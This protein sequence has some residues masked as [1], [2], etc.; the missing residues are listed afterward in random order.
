MKKILTI[1]AIFLLILSTQC[2]KKQPAT[3]TQSDPRLGVFQSDNAKLTVQDFNESFDG[4]TMD[5]QLEFSNESASGTMFGAADPKEYNVFSYTYEDDYAEFS[6]DGT[7]WN[8]KHTID[9][10][11]Q[12]QIK[13]DYSGVYK[14]ADNPEH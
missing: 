8:V 13:F 10:K 7:S 11:S 4:E 12:K 2:G 9:P 1:T 6:F 14:K 5:F 3:E